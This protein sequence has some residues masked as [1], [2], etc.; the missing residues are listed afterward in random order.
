M[1]KKKNNK[2]ILLKRITL[3]KNEYDFITIKENEALQIIENTK[4]FKEKGTK[5][6][7]AN[8]YERRKV[9]LRIFFREKKKEIIFS[10][11]IIALTFLGQFIYDKWI[12]P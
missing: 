4:E 11:I 8:F 6:V 1:K 12:K 2:S 5:Y 3:D 10:I 9:G 7:K